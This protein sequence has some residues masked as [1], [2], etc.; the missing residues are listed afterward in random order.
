[1]NK[2]LLFFALTGSLTA[3]QV[4]PNQTTATHPMQTMSNQSLTLNMG[5]CYGSCPVYQVTLYPNGKAVFHGE[6]YTKVIGDKVFAIDP[7]LYQQTFAKV[8]PYLP[9]LGKIENDFDCEPQVTD[10][11][12]IRLKWQVGEQKSEFW[13]DTGCLADEKQALTQ[14]LYDLPTTLN[15]ADF[16]Q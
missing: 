1:M 2:F 5:E 12:Q 8:R 6:K 7:V 14:Q 16:I 15:F 9:T 3:C 11:S 13:H 10:H 4:L